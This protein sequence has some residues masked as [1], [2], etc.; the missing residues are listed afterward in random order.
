MSSCYG[1][2]ALENLGEDNGSGWLIC[3][4]VYLLKLTNLSK[5][6]CEFH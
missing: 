5:T 3:D 1:N 2:V 4:S 6:K